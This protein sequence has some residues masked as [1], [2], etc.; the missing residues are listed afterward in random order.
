AGPSTMFAGSG[1]DTYVVTEG[2]AAQA[3]IVGFKTGDGLALSGFTAPQV[4]AALSAV[5]TGAF[6]TILD[7]PD[8]TRIILYGTQLS[9]S[10]ITTT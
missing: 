10:Q 4:S 3:G 5:T 1:T 8:G 7:L 9:A 2:L 6:G